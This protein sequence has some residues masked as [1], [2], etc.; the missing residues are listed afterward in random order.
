MMT[1][2]RVLRQGFD[3]RL[4]ATIVELP[5]GD[6]NYDDSLTN[7]RFSMLLLRPH[8]S[9]KSVFRSLRTFNVAKIFDALPRN[10]RDFE[11][12]IELT[13]P[14][15]E[16]NS[17]LNL[18]PVLERMGVRDVF[19]QGDANL[20][21]MFSNPSQPPYVSHVLHKARIQV[22][23]Y[24]TI[25]SAATVVNISDKSLPDDITFDRPFGYLIVDKLT[26]SILFAGQVKNPL[27]TGGD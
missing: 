24:G 20:S 18:K 26:N 2:T 15:F 14:K 19:S 1:Q 23:E 7:H 25:A 3:G 27:R 17:N 6:P 22:D 9:L 12:E 16:I 21:K 11:R 8:D 10:E 5:Y 4:G 13:V